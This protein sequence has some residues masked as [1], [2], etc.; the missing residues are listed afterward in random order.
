MIFC[1]TINQKAQQFRFSKADEII[2]K[3]HKFFFLKQFENIN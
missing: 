1:F 3:H 2:E